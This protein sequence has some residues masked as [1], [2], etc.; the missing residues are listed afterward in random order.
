MKVQYI[1]RGMI[2]YLKCLIRLCRIKFNF[3]YLNSIFDMKFSVIP[4][5]FFILTRKS[6]IV[7]SPRGELEPGALSLKRIKKKYFLL[8][9]KIAIYIFRRR[10]KIHATSVEETANIKKIFPFISKESIVL[11]PNIPSRPQTIKSIDTRPFSNKALKI[12]FISRITPKKNLLYALE[13]IRGLRIKADFDIYG[14]IED[15]TYWYKCLGEANKFPKNVNFRYHGAVEHSKVLQKLSN[16]DLF[17]FPTVGE[18]YGHII[19]ESLSV[20]CPVLISDTTPWTKEIL[21]SAGWVFP[22]AEK[23]SFIEKIN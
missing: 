1:S 6:S 5:A 12:C 10:I 11:A 19:Y 23:N 13:V 22:L 4:L 17:F 15:D 7:I 9:Y 3:I 8:V 21:D 2:P 16:S 14:P 20:G 18:N